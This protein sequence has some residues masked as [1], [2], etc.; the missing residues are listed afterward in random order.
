MTT[1]ALWRNTYEGYG[2]ASIILHWLSFLLVL[3]LLVEG[4]YMVTLTYYDP[5]YHTLPHWHKVAG[6]VTLLLTVGR[7]FWNRLTPRPA[8]LP[9]PRWQQMVARSVHWAFYGALLA[10]GVTG[11]VITTAKGKPIELVGG[12]Q[13]PALRSWP[14]DVA[15]L[16][17]SLHRWLAYSVGALTLLHG[18]AAL[19]HHFFHRDATLR[20]M[21]RPARK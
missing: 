15:E 16:T 2:W 18:G 1:P 9:A 4:I 5:L 10:L 3:F 13:I 17:G 7:L 12:L 20:R 21:L 8:L 19:Q 11:Y 14:T 6:V